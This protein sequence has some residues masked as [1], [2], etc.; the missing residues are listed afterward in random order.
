MEQKIYKFQ[1]F[2]DGTEIDET[3]IFIYIYI[4][5][6]LDPIFFLINKKIHMRFNLPHNTT[7]LFLTIRYVN[8]KKV[9]QASN[10]I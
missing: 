5:H 3:Y 1:V 10:S 6:N 9:F 2:I 7:F 8:S 4:L